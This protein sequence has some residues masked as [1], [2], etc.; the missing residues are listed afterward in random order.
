MR[1]F[2]WSCRSFLEGARHRLVRMA[3]AFMLTAA[4]SP[5]VQAQGAAP[6][7][8]QAGQG[9]PVRGTYGDWQMRCETLPGSPNEQCALVQTVSAQDRPN[10]GLL[11]IA[12]RTADQRTNM[13]RVIAPLGV[14]LTQGLG[15][16]IDEQ[17]IGATDFVRCV[18][19][20]CIADAR[21]N[22]ELLGKLKAGKSATFIIF[23][24][25]EEG[26]GIPVSLSGFKDG[27][28]KLQ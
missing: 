4:L 22:D 9:G 3:L 6:A 17:N 10:V 14:L 24:T 2:D 20:G 15:L 1:V 5:A 23:Q 27:F 7:G 21:L 18:P 13:L 25:P 16:R 11:V 8:V 28:N 12:F 26:I 19:N